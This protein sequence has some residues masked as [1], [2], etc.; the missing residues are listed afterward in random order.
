MFQIKKNI[1]LINL[2]NISENEYLKFNLINNWVVQSI[3]YASYNLILVIPLLVN[4]KRFIK[5]KKQIFLISIMSAIF[6]F[7]LA[8][9]IYLVLGNVN[10]FTGIEMPAVYAISEISNALRNIYGVVILLSIFTTSISLGI[11]FLEN[12]VL[13]KKYFPQIAGIMCITGVLIS[14]FGFSNLVNL[15]FP[16]FGFLGLFKMGKILFLKV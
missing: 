15:L 13:N 7:L 12:V 2:K 4:L 3:I 14:N 16:M 6:L 11:S 8:I 5:E 1:N 10:N 9:S